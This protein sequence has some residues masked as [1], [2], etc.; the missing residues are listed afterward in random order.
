MTWEEYVE[1]AS[2]EELMSAYKELVQRKT[3]QEMNQ[4][5]T[6]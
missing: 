5:V 4:Q 3:R 2:A 6:A 1:Q